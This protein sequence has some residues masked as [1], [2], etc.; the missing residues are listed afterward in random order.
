MAAKPLRRCSWLYSAPDVGCKGNPSPSRGRLQP[1]KS[2]LPGVSAPA[3][4]SGLPRLTLVAEPGEPGGLGEPW[5]AAAR[6]VHARP[7]FPPQGRWDPP[8]PA[9]PAPPSPAPGSRSRRGRRP[10]PTPRPPQRE[11]WGRGGSV[12]V[13]VCL[14]VWRSV[15]M[16]LCASGALCMCARLG[17]SVRVRVSDIVCVSARALGAVCVYPSVF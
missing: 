11:K 14:W 10:A 8:R 12:C 9:A 13:C 1:G 5:A 17:Y 15:C 6:K 16:Y 2:A 4:R 3:P 7:A